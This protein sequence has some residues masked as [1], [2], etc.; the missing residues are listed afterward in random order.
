MKQS[1]G[2]GT[3][4]LPRAW[5]LAGGTPAVVLGRSQHALPVTRV[6]P[7]RRRASGGGAVL[8]GPWLLRAAVR[9]PRGHA[10]LQHGP[11][12]L[13]RWMGSI[14]LGWL[15]DHGLHGACLYEGAGQDHWACF[16][17]RSPG[18]V[19]VGGRKLT[20]IAQRW[21][22]SGV[23]VSAG[24]LTDPPPWTSLCDALGRPASDAR[25]LDRTTT[26]LNACRGCVVDAPA[27]AERLR[28]ALVLALA[29]P[30]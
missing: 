10:L 5:A 8:A 4:K 23:L 18:E 26:S 30:A 24:T 19:L 25:E 7:I 17:G 16:G 11:G 21:Q 9:L 15:Q 29:A 2:P 3:G 12:S 13:A 20:G 14:H 28:T 27:L 22:R 1:A 6:L